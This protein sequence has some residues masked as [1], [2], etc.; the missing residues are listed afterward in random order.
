MK[1]TLLGAHLLNSEQRQEMGCSGH[2][3]QPSKNKK[4]KKNFAHLLN[5]EQREEMGRSGH[6]SQPSKKMKKLCSDQCNTPQPEQ[7]VSGRY[8]SSSTSSRNSLEQFQRHC[9]L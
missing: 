3:S 8:T 6:V 2:V 7:V 5:S 4:M 1:K 9:L